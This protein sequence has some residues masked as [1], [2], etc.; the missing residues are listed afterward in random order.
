MRKTLRA[1]SLTLGSL[2][3]AGACTNANAAWTLGNDSGGDGSISGAYPAF[4]LT[5]SND[6]DPSTQG[7]DNTVFYTQTFTVA[8]TVTFSW[9]YATADALAEYDT[10]G[11]ILDGSET[12]LFP[13]GD[14]ANTGSGS[15]TVS[16]GANDTFGFYVHSIDSLG[17]AAMLAVN[18]DLPPPPPPIP[19]PQDAVM[20][21]A[22]LAALFALARQRRD[23]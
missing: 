21:M 20:L 10:A 2:A 1:T 13:N 4:I 17:G 3:L 23:D 11:W 9:Q 8:A 12:E 16:V 18:E 7:F 5:G 14:I 15:T 6:A 19:E 22:G